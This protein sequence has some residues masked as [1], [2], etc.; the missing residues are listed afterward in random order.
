MW[1]GD[2]W[3]NTGRTSKARPALPD[4]PDH[5]VP[6]RRSRTSRSRR[7]DRSPALPRPCPVLPGPK[8]PGKRRSDRPTGRCAAGG[9]TGQSLAKSAAVDYATG[10]LAPTAA[11]GSTIP[12]GRPTQR[13]TASGDYTW[14]PQRNP[15]RPKV[16]GSFGTSQIITVADAPT[17][18]ASGERT[19]VRAA[20]AKAGQGD[21]RP[22]QEGELQR[23]AR[24]RAW[25]NG[26]TQGAEVRRRRSSPS[27]S[28]QLHTPLGHRR[29]LHG[30]SLEKLDLPRG[31]NGSTTKSFTGTR[32][33]L[34][35]F[36]TT[37]LPTPSRTR[38]TA[39]WSA[40]S[41]RSRARPGG[42]AGTSAV[43]GMI[44]PLAYADWPP[45]APVADTLYLRLAP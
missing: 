31:H 35:G 24:S 43:P 41:S 18:N 22:L 21:R 23:G 39:C 37:A 25:T 28:P 17:G 36:G 8:G 32:R 9:T 3:L 44:V 45:A 10:W 34:A 30:V 19:G 42:G 14:T 15:A 4:Q 13:G 26:G 5:R 27:S 2:E 16:A 7:S 33:D 29:D 6:I 20:F 38:R 1:T 11:G 40:T 12:R